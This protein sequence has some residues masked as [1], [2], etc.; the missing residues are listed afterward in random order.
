M[1][2]GGHLENEQSQAQER[3]GQ[4]IEAGFSRGFWFEL[5]VEGARIAFSLT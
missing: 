1:K 3:T 4:A 5:G 2:K